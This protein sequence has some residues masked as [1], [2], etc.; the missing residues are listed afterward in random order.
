MTTL[1]LPLIWIPLYM[2]GCLVGVD[3]CTVD[4]FTIEQNLCIDLSEMFSL[5]L[6][7]LGYLR[8]IEI[9]LFPSTITI[10]SVHRSFESKQPHDINYTKTISR[11]SISLSRDQKTTIWHSIDHTTSIAHSTD[12]ALQ[13]NDAKIN[14]YQ[15]LAQQS[16]PFIPSIINY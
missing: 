11:N 3:D 7:C 9:C 15:W 14:A 4:I 5:S 12:H 2:L 6:F 16:D 13:L 10:S 8:S 1:R